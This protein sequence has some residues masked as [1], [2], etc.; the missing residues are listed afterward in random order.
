MFSLNSLVFAALT[1][2]SFATAQN[3]TVIKVG[4]GGLTFTPPTVDVTNGDIVTFQFAGSPG[5]HS[6]TQASF[7]EPCDPVTGGFD[8]GFVFTPAGITTGFA[9]W[10]LTI[11]NASAPIWFFCKQSNVGGVHCKSGA[12]LCISLSPVL[13]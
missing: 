6:V 2:V 3:V 8:S 12:L 5:N 7:V 4:A 11:T 13:P 1:L 9:E 10:N